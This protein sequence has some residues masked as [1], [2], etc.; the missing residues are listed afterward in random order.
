[1]GGIHSLLDLVVRLFIGDAIFKP[2]PHSKFETPPVSR[3]SWGRFFCLKIFRGTI[4]FPQ[5]LVSF[6]WREGAGLGGLLLFRVV[7]FCFPG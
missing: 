6:L 7:Y 2:K 4:F 5:P 1:M 3:G